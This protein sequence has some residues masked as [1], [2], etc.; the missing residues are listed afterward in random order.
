MGSL[1]WCHFDFIDGPYFLYMLTGLT[2]S[3]TLASGSDSPSICNVYGK[4]LAIRTVAVR[5]RTF[6]HYHRADKS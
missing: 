5:I 4:E 2:T 3:L 6:L 1:I